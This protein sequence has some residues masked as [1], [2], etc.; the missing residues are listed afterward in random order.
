[1]CGIFCGESRTTA[2]HQ[3]ILCCG[4]GWGGWGGGTKH[5]RG[6]SQQPVCTGV[7]QQ[8]SLQPDLVLECCYITT[9]GDAQGYP[10]VICLVAND[11]PPHKGIG[12][13]TV[14]CGV[15]LQSMC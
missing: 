12:Y 13:A 10:H 8:M 9:S 11:I 6:G 2:V 15:V 14:V 3:Y 4:L 5:S 1:M 7:Q